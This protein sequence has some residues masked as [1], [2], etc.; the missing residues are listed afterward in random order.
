MFRALYIQ[1]E[2]PEIYL[3]DEN[4]GLLTTSGR[5]SSAQPKKNWLT[6]DFKMNKC[7]L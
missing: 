4:L 7:Y 5:I 2:N 6:G 1:T 3:K